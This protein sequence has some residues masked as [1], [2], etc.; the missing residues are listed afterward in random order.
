MSHVK[1]LQNSPASCEK[2]LDDGDDDTGVN[3][4]E[5][6]NEP[7]NLIICHVLQSGLI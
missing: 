4:F 5:M 1:A 6:K 7:V 2:V 3:D